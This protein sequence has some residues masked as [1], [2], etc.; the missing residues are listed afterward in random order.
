[1]HDRASLAAQARALDLPVD[2]IVL[3]H[4]SYR[5]VGPVVGGP[6]TVVEAL[7]DAF[8]TVTFAA[9]TFTTDRIDPYTWPTPPSAS[10]RARLLREM[11]PFDPETSRPHKMGAIAEALWRSPGSRRSRHPVTSWAA[12]GPR[13]ERLL[14]DHDLDD[15][16]GLRGPVGR[17]WEADG[18]VL[19]VGVDHD[20][21]TTIHLAESLL[22]LPHLRELP[23]R[24]PDD[25]GGA[26]IWRPI[27]KTT[28]CSDG[29][30]A[31]GPRLAPFTVRATLGDAAV[32][33]LRA[34]DIVRVA[35]DVLVADPT[36]LLCA[37]PECVHCPTSR[38]VLTPG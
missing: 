22:D 13:A 29:F 19:L 28:K 9:P 6:A 33:H 7:R 14:A 32:Q 11:A 31:I 20:A 3:V 38:R 27:R 26:R 21:D 25:S 10:D 17:A 23:D 12:V 5:A 36:A 34:R 16:E 4:S 35:T 15:P 2:G 18:R 30:V 1:M 24:W 8:P 37:D